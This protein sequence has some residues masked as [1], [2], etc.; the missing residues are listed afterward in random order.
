MTRGP[1]RPP[2]AEVRQTSTQPLLLLSRVIL[3]RNLLSFKN[4]S[5]GAYM[6]Y[7]QVD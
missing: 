1:L 6:S 5:H 2:V 7:L 3:D 4:L